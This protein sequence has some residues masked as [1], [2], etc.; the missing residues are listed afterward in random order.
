MMLLKHLLWAPWASWL[1]CL[2]LVPA[3]PDGPHSAALGH[4]HIHSPWNGSTVTGRGL[5]TFPASSPCFTCTLCFLLITSTLMPITLPPHGLF[6]PQHLP[7]Y[8]T[9]QSLLVF[10]E[11]C[12]TGDLSSYCPHDSNWWLAPSSLFFPVSYGNSWGI[13]L[14]HYQTRKTSKMRIRSY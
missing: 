3:L 4:S 12:P 5:A 7:F 8:S 9:G 14:S 2:S 10:Q 6:L 13:C 1:T 11:W